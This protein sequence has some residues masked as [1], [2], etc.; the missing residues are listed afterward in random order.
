MNE[1]LS[2][3]LYGISFLMSLFV[4]GGL[5]WATAKSPP[6][7]RF[8]LFLALAWTMNLVADLAWGILEMVKPE[9]WLDWI[10]YLYLGRYLLVFLAFY[11]FP[12]VWGWK[13]WLLMLILMLAGWILVWLL[14]ARPA[15]NPDSEYALA[16]M[17]FP[18]LDVGICYAAWH[19]WKAE[20]SPLK[21]SLAWIL[22]GMLSYGLANWFNY[23]VRITAPKGDSIFALIFWLLANVFAGIALWVFLKQK[24]S[25]KAITA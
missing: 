14:I 10:D 15:Q 21:T 25:Q 8:W 12:Q 2:T 13:Q 11:L 16:G 3:I 19:R 6:T 5:W 9:I 18:V 22:A 4:V 1:S 7:R 24:P 23:S 17:I 20:T